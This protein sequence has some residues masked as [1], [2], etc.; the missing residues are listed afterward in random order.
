MTFQKPD[1]INYTEMCIYIDNNI[2]EENC[3]LNL[4][5]QYLYHIVYML[6]KRANLFN[7]NCYYDDF[8]IFAA[9]KLYFRLTNK[10]QYEL[11]DTGY[12]MERIKSI[13]NYIKSILYPLKV[14][15]EQSEYS[16]TISRDIC[17]DNNNFN[18]ENLLNRS[19]SNIHLSDFKFMLNDVPETCKNFLR[20]LPYPNDSTEWLNIYIS[21]MLTF[22]NMITLPAPVKERLNHLGDMKSLND[23]HIISA[24]EKEH[25]RDAVLFHLPDHMSDYITVL[26][27]QLKNIVAKDLCYILHTKVTNDLL[28]IK[29]A[30][31]EIKESI[32]ENSNE[33]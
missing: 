19:Y 25:N 24:F 16:Q 3:D 4:I 5:Y 15:F 1:N 10:K 2:Y 28:L 31:E 20:T 33:Y 13:L 21:V 18:F 26:A 6:A 9:N 17:E 22:L 32:E 12:K 7:R 23:E 30:Q 29:H 8:A 14:T 11:S 27:R